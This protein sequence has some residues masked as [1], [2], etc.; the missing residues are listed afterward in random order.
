MFYTFGN[1]WSYH[2]ITPFNLKKCVAGYN[3][4]YNGF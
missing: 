1:A 4:G 3:A 2:H